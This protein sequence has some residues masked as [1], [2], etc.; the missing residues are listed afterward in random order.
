MNPESAKPLM[1][2]LAIATPALAVLILMR[3]RAGT[4]TRPPASRLLLLALMGPANLTVW[5]LF[6]GYLDRVGHR[7]AIGIALAALV[8]IAMGFGAGFVR[9]GR[10]SGDEN[11]SGSRAPLPP[12]EP[13]AEESETR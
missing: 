11:G 3:A 1:I 13:P 5:I 10:R 6:N 12:G 8:F 2:V 7:S 9:A 4:M